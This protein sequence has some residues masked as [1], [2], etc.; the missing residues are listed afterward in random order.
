MSVVMHP[1]TI[2]MGKVRIGSHRWSWD[3]WTTPPDLLQTSGSCCPTVGRTRT[4]L[5]S[6]PETRPNSAQPGMGHLRPFKLGML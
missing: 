1:P 5:S 3:F 4:P 6:S 2:Q